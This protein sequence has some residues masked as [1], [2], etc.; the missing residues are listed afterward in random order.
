VLQ[1]KGGSVEAGIAPGDVVEPLDR[2]LTGLA[3]WLGLEKYVV[4]SR[5]GEL[6]RAL[7]RVGGAAAVNRRR[8]RTSQKR[9]SR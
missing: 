8:G 3:Q 2:L 1:V 5:R 4:T 7:R 9:T 6:M